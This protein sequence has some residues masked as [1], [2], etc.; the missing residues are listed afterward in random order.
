MNLVQKFSTNINSTTHFYILCKRVGVSWFSVEYF[1]SH[2]TKK[3]RRVTIPGFRIILVSK[4]FMH[5]S[6]VSWFSVVWITLKDV[7]EGCDS[8]PY[9][10]PQNVVVL[11]T[12][13]CEQLDFPTDISKI[14]KMYG[15]TEIWTQTY[16]LRNFCPHCTAETYYLKIKIVGE[17]TLKKKIRPYC[18][19]WIIFQLFLHIYMRRKT[20][21]TTNVLSWFCHFCATLIWKVRWWSVWNCYQN[22][23]CTR[24][25]IPYVPDSMHA[26]LTHGFERW[27][28]GC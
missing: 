22:Y 27:R 4:V 12:V 7:R 11:P 5:K 1:L 14:I 2:S 28:A 16:R 20:K 6:L 9:L 21:S 18:T 24:V 10:A 25:E 26:T 19:E 23:I 3:F 13:P 15:P 8:N 17:N